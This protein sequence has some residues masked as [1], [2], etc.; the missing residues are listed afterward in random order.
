MEIKAS[1]TG[2]EFQ[3]NGDIYEGQTIKYQ[4]NLQIIQEEI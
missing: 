4:I 1:T 2:K 3:M